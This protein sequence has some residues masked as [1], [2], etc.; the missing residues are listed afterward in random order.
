MSFYSQGPHT[1]KV[2][3]TL[4][5]ENRQRFFEAFNTEAKP[6]DAEA[7]VL[8]GG[9]QQSQYDTDR[10]LLFR[11]ESYFHYLYGVKEPDCYAVLIPVIKLSV[12]L[13][14]RLPQEYAVWMG[15]I[16][17][18]QFFKE[19]YLVDEVMYVDELASFLKSKGI[20]KIHVIHGVNSDSGSSSPETSFDGMTDFQVEKGVLYPILTECR[21]IKSPEEIKLL[22]YVNKV[23]SDAH[24]YVMRNCKVGMMEYQLESM[25]LHHVYTF[26]GCRHVSYTCICPNGHQTAV[27]H[28]GHAGAPNDRVIDEGTMLLLDMGAEYHCYG[29]DITCSY[30]GGSLAFLFSPFLQ[31]RTAPSLRSEHIYITNPKNE[32]WE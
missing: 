17:A 27:L 1:Y 16:K 15:E 31:N 9:K 32:Y 24:K 14:P 8:Q 11:Q 25:F 28:Y 26:G 10:E 30:P 19:H 18:P 29:S 6:T 12:L 4:H 20:A 23:S 13:I 21:V 7:I 2:P 5:A 3:F 22:R